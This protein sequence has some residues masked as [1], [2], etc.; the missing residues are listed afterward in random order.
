[1]G[2]TQRVA[3]V[4]AGA[5]GLGALRALS[6]K[7][8]DAIA[9]ERG[10]AI[11]GVG[12][13]ED[14]PTAA[15]RS[16]HLITSR[17]RT[18]F[19]EFPMPPGTPDY[20]ARD[21][22]GRYLDAYAT[23]FGLHERVRLGN[24][25]RHARRRPGDCCEL[26]LED[27]ARAEADVLVAANGH[28]ELPAWP[29]PPYPGADDFP[30]E[31]LHALDYREAEDFR[32]RNVLVVG[33]GNS[34]MDIATDLSHVA[35]RT[36]L[37]T[38]RGTW[39]IPKRLL[40][41][42]ADQVIRPWVAVHVPWRVPPAPSPLLPR[43]TLGAPDRYGLPAPERGI[44]QAHPTITD[45]VLSR[46]SHGRITPKP[47]LAALDGDGVRFVDGTSE[48]VDAIVWCTGYRVVI[49]FLDPA[50]VGPDP[51][52]LPLYKRVLHLDV[53]DLF[54]VGLMQSTGSAFPIV[55]RQSELLAARLAGEWAPPSPADMR[56]DCV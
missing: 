17:A 4:G 26:E 2:R 41:Q 31:Q 48:P 36:L 23:H 28:N 19:E 52:N 14:R 5:S 24:G 1:M 3:V 12:T 11:G 8:F 30:G 7:G 22:V 29:D 53:D 42:P 15:Y 18:E 20:P 10:G 39:V 38:R 27:G 51:K 43:V 6:A 21:E 40:G 56:K 25:V 32:D 16:L 44:F 50:L 49:P 54:F 34:A 9:Y 13:L 55:E 46:I 45:T 47:G 37:S 33:M 35:A